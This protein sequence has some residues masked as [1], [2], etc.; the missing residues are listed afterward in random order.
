MPA[1]ERKV[2]HAMNLLVLALIAPLSVSSLEQGK[3]IVQSST[4]SA[5]QIC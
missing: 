1:G 5:Y 3:A 2:F 4:W